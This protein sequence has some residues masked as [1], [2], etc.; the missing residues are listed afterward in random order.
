MTLHRIPRSPED[1]AAAVGEWA[2]AEESHQLLTVDV[3][4]DHWT[5]ALTAA[6]DALGL[7]YFDWLS[8]VDELAEGFSVVAHLAAVGDAA[9]VRHLLLRTRVPRDAASLPTATGVYAG[10]SWHERETHEMFGIDFPGHPGLAVLLLPDGFEGHPLRK[11]FV[12]AAR[13]AKAWPGAKEPG[14]SD[15]G[16]GQPAAG[17]RRMLPPGVPD[18][19]EWG[20]LKGTLPPVAERPAR[21]ARA[22]AA[23]R[24]A[25]AAGTAGERPV[26]A[27]RPRRTRSVSA[28]SASQA[29]APEAAEAPDEVG[30]QVQSPQ[31]SDDT[32]AQPAAGATPGP[33]RERRRTPDA[34]W[35]TAP[36][37]EPRPEG[38]P[39]PE[40]RGEAS[41]AE[42]GTEP[43]P[44]A[45]PA[46]GPA[47]GSAEPAPGT[48]EPQSAAEPQPEP[49]TGS[50]PATGTSEP[51]PEPGTAAEP[52]SGPA[53][54]DPAP[55]A[56][57][58]QPRSDAE[59]QPEP[60]TG[61]EPATGPATSDPG[62]ATG[63]AEP[64]NDT[65]PRPDGDGA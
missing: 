52:A 54:S 14:E 8:A 39:E 59:P 43:K 18:P 16:E 51:Q 50:G 65:E 64:Q 53:T 4:A 33:Q 48:S 62:P 29:A 44:E 35:Q 32:G 5:E 13:V 60:G 24:A 56:G 2:A 11:E 22:G 23:G 49:G 26:R 41:T 63:S 37:P 40:A 61:A 31:T 15:H 19:N 30:T 17:R 1:V 9:P 10:A 25:A 6:R 28:G 12:L 42:P 7:A 27:D 36:S 46:T 21:G 55:A 57:S 20:P 34:P 3:P 38:E 47:A 58:A 45:K